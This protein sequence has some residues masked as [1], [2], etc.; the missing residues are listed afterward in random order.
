MKGWD[1]SQPGIRFF[2][3]ICVRHRNNC[4]IKSGSSE[5]HSTNTFKEAKAPAH[6]PQW[7][8]ATEKELASLKENNVYDLVPRKADPPGCKVI[9]SRWVYKVKSDYTFKARL[10]CQGYAQRP[11]ID[12]GATFAPV[13]R[14]ESQ[15]ILMA[16]ACYHDWDIVMLD[17]K[18]AFLQAPSTRRPT[19][20]SLVDT[21]KWMLKASP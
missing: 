11:G 8:K 16:I 20:G 3:G 6:S 17:V 2:C 18:T 7:T 21:R 15:R 9:G 19:F 5:H 4:P 12:C 1:D 10:V 13:R 14:I